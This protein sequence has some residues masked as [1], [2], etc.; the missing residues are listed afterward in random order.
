M[1]KIFLTIGFFLFI[2]NIVPAQNSQKTNLS[3]QVSAAATANR[4]QLVNYVWTRTIKVFEGGELKLTTVNSMS[5]GSD[6]K[7]VASVVSSTPAKEPKSGIL[8]DKDR[9]RLNE[10]KGYVENAMTVGQGYIYLSKGKMVDYF[11]NA[12][13]T[14][15]DKTINVAGNNVIKTGD[16]L[17]MNIAKG[18]LAYLNQ[19]FKTTLSNKENDPIS[20]TVNY[21]T[22][23]NGLTGVDNGEM[24]LLAKNLKLT[25]SNT[26]YAKKMH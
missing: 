15:V 1:K 14:E 5:V 6:G 23:S 20:G 11:E 9:K 19:S 22:F 18:T 8:G 16:Q 4:A 10:L 13:I 21:K 7:L 24:D 17:T 26:N 25:L 3:L 2:L 12:K